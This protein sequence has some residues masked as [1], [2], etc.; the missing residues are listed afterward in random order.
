MNKVL[1][2]LAYRLILIGAL[3]FAVLSTSS[4]SDT[5]EATCN[6]YCFYFAGSP[7]CRRG[8]EWTGK[9]GCKIDYYILYLAHKI[10]YPA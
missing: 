2:R 10:D 9:D 3:A 5:A 4:E 7:S 8:T 6:Q 1:T